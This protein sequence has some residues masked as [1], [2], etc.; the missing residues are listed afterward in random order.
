MA[1]KP[2]KSRIKKLI[3]ALRSGK[4]RQ[5]TG[6]LRK[7]N[8]FCCLGV[9]C[10]VHRK[11]TGKGRWRHIQG[12]WEYKKEISLLPTDVSKWFGITRDPLLGG[13]SAASLNDM[14]KADFPY[15]ADQ[16]EKTFI[17]PTL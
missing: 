1:N 5:T 15:I 14:D 2:V 7:G 17:K 11:A 6:A 10:E 16:F 9:A 13:P 12:N 8:R 3:A 4:Y